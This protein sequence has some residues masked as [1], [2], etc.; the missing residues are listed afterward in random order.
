MKKY[1]RICAS[2]IAAVACVVFAAG[3]SDYKTY[4]DSKY[5]VYDSE[6]YA[7]GGVTVEQSLSCLEVDW[8]CGDV[9]IKA[10]DGASL[11][12][13]EEVTKGESDDDG[14]KL[15]Y[16]IKEN[17]LKIRFAASGQIIPT[18]FNK[19][20]TVLVPQNATFSEVEVDCI[21]ASVS[22][23]D[24]KINELEVDSVLGNVNITACEIGEAE[25]KSVSG[26]IKIADVDS[27][28]AEIN[29]TSGEISFS[30]NAQK[31]EIDNVSGNI[32]VSVDNLPTEIEVKSTSGAVVFNPKGERNF[33]IKYSTTS[34][35]Y[36]SD[37]PC[38]VDGKYLIYG[39]GTYTYKIS[40][41]SG[42]LTVN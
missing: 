25:I 1:M 32:D 40:T 16:L 3:C 30:G 22:V 9:E 17:T 13:S 23:S 2:I 24:L 27:D 4:N 38:T 29:S 8:L 15:R 11:I 28:F 35:K 10:H 5:S 34:G 42:N 33:K 41:T 21:S 19:T 26:K 39:E 36:K 37:L 31:I 18:K 12:F 7:I 20:L 14:L 6:N